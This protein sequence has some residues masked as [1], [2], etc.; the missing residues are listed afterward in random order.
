M[1]NKYL[2]EFPSISSACLIGFAFRIYLEYDHFSPSP[3]LQSLH[4]LTWI[5]VTASQLVSLLL[6]MHSC[7]LFFTWQPDGQSPL[8]F[9]S[10]VFPSF[11]EQIGPKAIRWDKAR[12]ALEGGGVAV[13]HNDVGVWMGWGICLCRKT[14]MGSQNPKGLEGIQGGGVKKVSKWY[15]EHPDVRRWED[16]TWVGREDAD[17]EGR[18]IR[19][20]RV[21]L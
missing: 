14:G 13:V 21:Q 17:G 8:P 16:R 9:P 11:H 1:K 5:I 15:R 4:Y 10:C 12:E 7:I 19:G 18:P 6:L 2:F 20:V 3:L